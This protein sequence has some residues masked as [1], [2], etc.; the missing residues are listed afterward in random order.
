[1]VHTRRRVSKSETAMRPAALQHRVA[2]R[3]L[4]APHACA[5]PVA[6]CG[7]ASRPCARKQAPLL[8][9]GCRVSAEQ[10][11]QEAACGVLGGVLGFELG[12]VSSARPQV[13]GIN[14]QKIKDILKR[15][16]S[17][18]FQQKIEEKSSG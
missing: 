1:M 11:E 13:R 5:C 16:D 15:V 7:A 6:P 9:V 4:S 8:F 17:S 10:T 12:Q 2:R 14:Q 3:A 18:T